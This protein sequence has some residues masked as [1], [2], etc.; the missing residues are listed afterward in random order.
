[1]EEKIIQ[2][3]LNGK[4]ISQLSKEYP[5]NYRKIQ[6]LLVDNNVTIRGGRKKKTL[7]E[8]QEKILKEE[9]DKGTPIKDIAKLVGLDSETLANMI[10]ERKYTRTVNRV[11]R[12]IKSDYFSNI[13]TPE[14]AY[15]L[16]F[17]F[18]DGTVDHYGATGRIRL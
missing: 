16:G 7:T 2:E 5:L 4:S 15:W 12:R 6:K 10:K 3:Y 9:F 1:M 14:K 11:N 13:D 8:K 17:L 18:T